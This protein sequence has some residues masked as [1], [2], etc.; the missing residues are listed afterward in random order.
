[1]KRMPVRWA[2]ASERVELYNLADDIGET[3]NLA[4]VQP[5]RVQAMRAKLAAL[6]QDALPSAGSPQFKRGPAA[7]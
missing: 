6:T 5:E 2:E 4:A 3:K 1:M 7:Q